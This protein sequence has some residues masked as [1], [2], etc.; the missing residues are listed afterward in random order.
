MLTDGALAPSSTTPI[1]PL[2]P[3]PQSKNCEYMVATREAVLDDSHPQPA[4]SENSPRNGDGDGNEDGDTA[5]ASA[6]QPS[7]LRRRALG[8]FAACFGALILGLEVLLSV[9]DKR[10]GLASSSAHLHYIWKYGPTAVLTVITASWRRVVFQAKMTAPWLRLTHTKRPISAEQ[11][12]LLDYLDMWTH[13]VLFTACRHRDWLVLLSTATTMALLA[14]TVLSTSLLNLA[15]TRVAQPVP[16]V[17][18]SRFRN[19]ASLME[20]AGTGAFLTM[21]GLVNNT[22]SFPDGTSSRFVH[23]KFTY[24][25]TKH[26]PDTEM[27][28][29]VDGIAV[30]VQCKGANL[31]GWRNSNTESTID[32]R[33]STPDCR[34]ESTVDTIS[35]VDKSHLD[36]VARYWGG[37]C[38]DT[39]RPGDFRLGV[40]VMELDKDYE[41]RLNDRPPINRAVQRSTQLICSPTY[42]LVKLDVMSQAGNVQQLALV[43]DSPPGMLDHVGLS[44]MLAF[45]YGRS[46]PARLENWARYPDICGGFASLPDYCD[47]GQSIDLDQ[48]LVLALLLYGPSPTPPLSSLF[49]A[50][51]LGNFTAYFLQQYIIQ[52]VNEGLAEPTSETVTGTSR[53]L[54]GRLLVRSLPT[55]WMAACLAAAMSLAAAMVTLAPR[56]WALPRPPNTIVGIALNSAARG[57]ILQMLSNPAVRAKVQPKGHLDSANSSLSSKRQLWPWSS[58]TRRPAGKEARFSEIK[59]A[60]YPTTPVDTAKRHGPVAIKPLARS[61]VIL[62]IIALIVVLE[63]LLRRSQRSDGLAEI[64]DGDTVFNYLWSFGPAIISLLLAAYHTC[65]DFTVRSRQPLKNMCGRQG[66]PYASTVGLNLVD[67]SLPAIVVTEVKTRAFG[68]L[69]TTT[70]SLLAA[71]LTVFSASLFSTKSTQLSSSNRLQLQDAFAPSLPL[72]YNTSDWGFIAAPL[73]LTKNMS[74]PAFTY[75]DLVLPRLKLEVPFSGNGTGDMSRSSSN[76]F[77]VKATVPALRPRLDCRFYDPSFINASIIDQEAKPSRIEVELIEE[78]GTPLNWTYCKVISADFEKGAESEYTVGLG[79]INSEIPG[80][81]RTSLINSG[82]G[83]G[84]D[85]VFV[86][87]TTSRSS[88]EQTSITGY[89]CNETIEAVE[90]TVHLVGPDL[91]IDPSNPPGITTRPPI[92]TLLRP[93]RTTSRRGAAYKDVEDIYMSSAQHIVPAGPATIDQFFRIL[94]TS[95]L[96][97]TPASA[98]AD[99]TWTQRITAAIQRQHAIIRAQ[100]L[101][102]DYRRPVDDAQD[103]GDSI[104][105]INLLALAAAGGG[106]GQEEDPTNNSVNATVADP[107]GRTRLLQDAG[108]TRVLEGLL[109]AVLVFSVAGWVLL[110]RG[111][112]R[113]R[114]RGRVGGGVNDNRDGDGLTDKGVS[115]SDSGLGNDHGVGQQP[116]AA[117]GDLDLDLDLAVWG[118]SP[119][120]IAD[121][122]ALLVGSN[123][124]TVLDSAAAA[125]SPSEDDNGGLVCG[126]RVLGGCRF[127]LGWVD[128]QGEETAERDSLEMEADDMEAVGVHG[129]EWD[130]SFSGTES[131]MKEEKAA[132]A[133]GSQVLSLIV[134]E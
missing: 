124:W 122:A 86:W 93:N 45:M 115:D 107:Q 95:P 133:G 57:G 75:E 134:I 40:A 123:I 4:E 3:T 78:S 33:I 65:V 90:T 92:T 38:N 112:L 30:D 64:L 50:P 23:Q 46:M 104:N 20:Q 125:S 129:E 39:G 83:C 127:K 108:S 67:S 51:M 76:P 49:D 99:E 34:L 82:N 6:W 120:C 37:Y 32:V 70:A 66:A 101:S 16:V 97:A 8:G 43:E 61:A 63:T 22:L 81:E 42:S 74:Y 131:A 52:A 19:D 94:T 1:E 2:L 54:V 111:A 118:G 18:Q 84:A 48:R 73:I 91:R 130:G 59:S 10:Q 41:S 98:L 126:E 60:S 26:G 117:A 11:T 110:S 62:T 89:G 85:F 71:V 5:P 9:S 24:D 47:K 7:Y 100:S 79:A 87:G 114:N 88:S 121:V 53:A 72:G 128:A 13:Q 102:A 119:T 56:R 31:D 96:L 109:G 58:V 103:S 106:T 27:R 14:A 35:T 44:D 12:I 36:L 17:L 113:F 29:V 116:R 28:V 25:N 105:N 132:P 69:C 77:N 80:F 55:H 15:P 68:P 21:M